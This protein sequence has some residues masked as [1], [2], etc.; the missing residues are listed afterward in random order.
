[1][2]QPIRL[3]TRGSAL[4]MVQARATAR[5]LEA[6]GHVVKI[7]VK[8]TI[9]DID[10][11]SP[12]AQVGAPG[13]FVREI[14]TALVEGEL[15]LAVHCFK[16][17]PSESPAGLVI[18]A[19]PFREDPREVLVTR[20]TSH[21]PSQVG[22]P[23]NP[24]AVIG[25]SAARRRALINAT[26]EDITCRDLR[27]NVPTRI[28]KLQ[29]GDYD[30]ILLAAAGLNRLAAG[31]KRGENDAPNL[32]GL[33][34]DH[35]AP[36]DFVPAASQGA[37]ALQI[38]DDDEFMRT[39]IGHLHHAES[40]RTIAGEREIL[41]L[42]QAGCDAPFGAYC[43]STGTDGSLVLRIVFEHE[44]VLFRVVETGDDPISLAAEVYAQLMGDIA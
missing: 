25:T 7:C 3:G 10:K 29:N 5:A 39:A 1:M 23:L 26:F 20:A 12:F 36:R 38:R 22:L 17:L 14:E 44:N 18:G 9:G 35:L 30:A 8:N 21:Q 32:A 4:A 2:S 37:L 11:T 33:V 40:A 28:A 19:V 43:E 31:A 41:R 15:D 6:A 34:I 42:V 16:D 24:G 13:I 27:G